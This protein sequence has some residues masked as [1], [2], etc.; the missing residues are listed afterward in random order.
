MRGGADDFERGAVFG[1][2]GLGDE[3][4]VF[5]LGA[6]AP[7]G[8][9]LFAHEGHVGG[10]GGGLAGARG[11]A[12]AEGEVGVCGGSAVWGGGCGGHG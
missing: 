9:F 12:A 10:G 11:G 7:D 1:G 5:V 4:W 3:A 6:V 8:G 2:F